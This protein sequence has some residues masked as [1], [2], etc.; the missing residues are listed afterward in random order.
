LAVGAAVVAALAA[1]ALFL[2]RVVFVLVPSCWK[3]A[4]GALA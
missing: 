2:S 3:C 1:M 4:R